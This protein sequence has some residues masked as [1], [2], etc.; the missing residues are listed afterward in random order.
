MGL[1]QIMLNQNNTRD[2]ISFFNTSDDD[3]EAAIARLFSQSDSQ[4]RLESLLHEVNWMP[5][6]FGLK[7]FKNVWSACD[8]TS[9]LWDEV[10]HFL[11]QC[12]EVVDFRA[13]LTPEEH[14]WF[15]TLPDRFRVCRGCDVSRSGGLSWTTNREVAL[16]F[17]RGHRGVTFPNPVV[18]SGAVHKHD[19]LFATN[20]RE[21]FEVLVEFASVRDKRMTSYWYGPDG[22]L[23][24]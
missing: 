23:K 6:R 13:F 22:T 3:V 14:V 5:P 10:E 2:F 24:R 9:G 21:E 20:D 1:N 8:D 17:A 7:L 4:S 15:G 16:S 12:A 18:L 19:V 11:F